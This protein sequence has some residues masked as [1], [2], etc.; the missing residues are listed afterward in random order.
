MVSKIRRG[1]TLIELLVV[2]AII[3]V[4]IALLLPAV[5]AAREAARRAQCNNNLKQIGLALH[6]YHQT[7]NV[8]PPGHGQSASQLNYTGGYAGWG[9]WSAQ[10]M[11]LNYMEQAPIYNAINFSFCGGYSYGAFCNVSVFNSVI[12]T[13][14]CPS[15]N[16][17]DKG[18]PPNNTPAGPAGWGNSNAYP[19]NINSYRG[20]I[21]TTTSRYNWPPNTGYACC[22]PDPLN[23]Q[24]GTPAQKPA[25]TGM[26]AYWVCYGIQDVTDGTSSTIL[27]AE[28]L[29]GDTGGGTSTSYLSRNNSV[30]NVTA[31][32]AAEAYDASSLSYAN[33]ILPALNACTTNMKANSS[34]ATANGNRWA[35]GAVGMTLFNTVVTPNRHPVE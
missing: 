24:G 7:N 15:D 18:G 9:E 8:F 33:V 6:N 25:S 23:M 34:V 1:F 21:G 26:F 10:A 35:W 16:Q 4:L 20:S 19:P 27:F 3:A 2:I 22:T 29:V 13:F 28:S 17:V 30:T 14:M 5:Q 32:S 12:N 11:M 31:A